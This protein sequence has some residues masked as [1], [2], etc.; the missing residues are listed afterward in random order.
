[1][2]DELFDDFPGLRTEFFRR[3]SPSTPDYNCIAW[4]A[5][6]ALNWWEPDSIGAYYWPADVPRV[7]SLEAFQKAYGTLGYHVCPDAAF[8]PGFEKVAVYASSTGEPT[9]AAR[10]LP[11]GRW[12]SKLGQDVDIEHTLDGLISDVYGAPAVYLRRKAVQR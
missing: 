9:H 7:V 1:M 2:T 3:T 6:D 5:E 12:T 8:E 4:A 11:N 10:Q